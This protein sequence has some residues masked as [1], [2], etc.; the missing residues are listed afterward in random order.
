VS[1][2]DNSRNTSRN[3]SIK[4]VM[5]TPK[6]IREKERERERERERENS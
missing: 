4:I 5:R 1:K 3:K 6:Q 2:I